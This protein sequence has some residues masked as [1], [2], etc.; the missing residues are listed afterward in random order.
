MPYRWALDTAAEWAEPTR[1][2]VC[3]AV[4]PNAQALSIRIEERRIE[5]TTMKGEKC[6]H[7]VCSCPAVSGKYCSVQC[8]AMV[9]KPDI[10]CSCGH[11]GCD[12][13]TSH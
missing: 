10:D 4:E 2:S 9:K 8:E 6:A 13:R 1:H 12:G 5:M 11:Q 3:A 7:P